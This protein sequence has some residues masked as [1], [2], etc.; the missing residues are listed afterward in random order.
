LTE[1]VNCPLMVAM[2]SKPSQA[3]VRSVIRPGRLLQTCLLLAS[4]FL[5]S[6]CGEK[7]GV[8][9]DGSFTGVYALV[10]VDGAK[11]PATVSHD[12]QKI[13][14]R[15]GTFTLGADGMCSSTTTFVPP[16]GA[17]ATRE[18][19]ATYTREG[20]TLT[21]KWEGAGTTRGTLQGGTFT[22]DNE[23]M[24]LVYRK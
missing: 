14:V 12:G 6:S 5:L 10:T 2:R 24:T 3:L 22:M 23:G 21:L 11:V 8:K 16:G 1:A 18:T 13:Q 15:S 7:P 4:G 9:P 19:K 20:S 17:E